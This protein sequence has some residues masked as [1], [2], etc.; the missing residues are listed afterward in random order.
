MDTTTVT[1]H[2]DSDLKER[3]DMLF[4]ELGMDF[5][6]AVNVFIRQSLRENRIPFM[7]ALNHPIEDTI[8]AMIEAKMLAHNQSTKSYTNIEDLLADLEADPIITT[9]NIHIDP[10]LN[11]QADKLFQELGMDF[12]TA[13]N[14]FVRQA[15]RKNRIPF[16]IALTLP[17]QENFSTMF[18]A[19]NS[20]VP[21]TR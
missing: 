2:I 17:G 18:K 9:V 7:I 10:K 3:A 1:I 13:V 4:E 8:A 20:E 19:D 6:T 14:I 21:T 15:L 5:S 16:D 11:D 12:S